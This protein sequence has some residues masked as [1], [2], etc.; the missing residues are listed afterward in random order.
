MHPCLCQPCPHTH[1]MA[2]KPASHYFSSVTAT[3]QAVPHFRPF[4]PQKIFFPSGYHPCHP[5]P[6]PWLHPSVS[7]PCCWFPFSCLR[8]S[9][10]TSPSRLCTLIKIYVDLAPSL[11]RGTCCHWHNCIYTQFVRFLP[12]CHAGPATDVIVF[13]HSLFAFFLYVMLVLQLAWQK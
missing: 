3:P 8:S 4:S 9:V 13:I 5:T 10:V 1:S 11:H 7:H 12:V 6:T 2:A